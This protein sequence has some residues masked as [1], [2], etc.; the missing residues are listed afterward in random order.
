[1]HPVKPDTHEIIFQQK[2]NQSLLCKAFNECWVD[3]LDSVPRCDY[4][5]LLHADVFTE[6][7]GWVGEMVD[8]MERY[9][10]DVLHAPVLIKDGRG[11]TSTAVGGVSY[12]HEWDGVRRLTATEISKLPPVF[13]LPDVLQLWRSSDPPEVR[14]LPQFGNHGFSWSKNDGDLALLP[15][16]GMM[17]IRPGSMMNRFPGF[18][19]KDRIILKDKNKWYPPIDGLLAPEGHGLKRAVQVISEDWNFGRWCAQ[20]ELKVGGIRLPTG[21]HGNCTFMIEQAADYGLNHDYD[22]VKGSETIGGL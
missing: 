8:A 19:I 4:F 9:S 13:T 22:I 21:H 20:H 10:L 11:K 7:R 12:D 5:L 15:N 3:F 1:M 17:I 18:T 16:T 6:R 2:P 14:S